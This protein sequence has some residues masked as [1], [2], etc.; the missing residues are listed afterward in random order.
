MNLFRPPFGQLKNKQ[1][2]VLVKLG[3]KVVMWSV[4]AFD[5]EQNIPKAQSLKHVINAASER[6][7]IIVFHDSVKASRILMYVLARVLEYFSNRG[8]TFKTMKI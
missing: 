4:I 7:N 5:W 8:Y 3:Y 1:G 6:N 2:K